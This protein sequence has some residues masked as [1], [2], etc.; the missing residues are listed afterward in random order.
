MEAILVVCRRLEVGHMNRRDSGV[1]KDGGDDG[2]DVD[3][4]GKLVHL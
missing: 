3:L 4:V 1:S 2:S